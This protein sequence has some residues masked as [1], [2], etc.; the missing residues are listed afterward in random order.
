MMSLGT[1]GRPVT[2][3]QVA[4]IIHCG[5]PQDSF[6]SLVPCVPSYCAREIWKKL[7]ISVVGVKN[8]LRRLSSVGSL[9]SP[10][11]LRC[12]HSLEL[13]IRHHSASVCNLS[14]HPTYT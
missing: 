7:S 12:P 8:Q 10:Y 13:T 9:L 14:E 6:E 1:R 3:K 11:P 5:L 4:M 2:K